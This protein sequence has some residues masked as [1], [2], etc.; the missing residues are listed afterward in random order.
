MTL[1]RQLFALLA[2]TCALCVAGEGSATPPA[3]PKPVAKTWLRAEKP[4]PSAAASAPAGPSN[5]RMA[6]LSGLV[7][8]LAG[9]AYIVK[10]RR[11]VTVLRVAS[12]L[13]VLTAARVGAKADVVV[14][15]VAGRRLLLGVTESQVTR[16][17]WLEGPEDAEDA[18]AER[19]LALP[20][21]SAAHTRAAALEPLEVPSQAAL[22]PSQAALV[23][24]PAPA[25]RRF[26]DALLGAL[27]RA[28]ASED[29][30]VLIAAATEDVVRTS[31]TRVA[32][33]AG[34]PEMVDVEGQ[35]RGLVLRL[36]KRA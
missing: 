18:A 35:A 14:V 10:R 31:K 13:E 19:E 21:V 5:V 28:P 26:R 6:L 4:K 30:A 20:G 17:A 25:P 22:V 1:A 15:R 11:R 16:L 27:G 2:F 33:P 34:A 24:A 8:L 23:P 7:A 32:A 3:E 9:A 36:Q 12:G 29:A